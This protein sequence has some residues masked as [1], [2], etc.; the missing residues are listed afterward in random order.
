MGWRSKGFTIHVGGR[1]VDYGKGGE[2]PDDL[3]QDLGLAARGLVETDGADVSGG[4]A[5]APSTTDTEKP[6]KKKR[7]GT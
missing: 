2:V 3:V 4:L 6:K 7:R 5:S 1:P